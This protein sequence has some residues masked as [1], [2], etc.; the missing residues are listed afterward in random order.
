MKRSGELQSVSI[1]LREGLR[2]KS[3]LEQQLPKLPLLVICP[4]PSRFSLIFRPTGLDRN[5]L[6]VNVN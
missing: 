1:Q 3:R 5:P 4:K 2:E 6:I